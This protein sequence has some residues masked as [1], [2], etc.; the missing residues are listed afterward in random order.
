ML[1]IVRNEKLK[2]ALDARGLKDYW[3]AKQVGIDPA[4]FSRIN[5]FKIIFRSGC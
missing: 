5:F 4:D 3:V 2:K 1:E